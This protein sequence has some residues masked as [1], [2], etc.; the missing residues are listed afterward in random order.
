MQDLGVDYLDNYYIHFPIA[1]KFVPIEKRYPPEWLYDPENDKVIVEE[2]V[3]L[4]ETWRAM[5]SLVEEGLVRNISIC[6]VG[7]S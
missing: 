4:I 1:T 5:E 6:N 2:N 7:V 3:P